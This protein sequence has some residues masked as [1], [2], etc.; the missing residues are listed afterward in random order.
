M[1]GSI[2]YLMKDKENC[3]E[4]YPKNPKSIADSI[5]FILTN[6][7]VIVPPV[8]KSASKTIVNYLSEKNKSHS[9]LLIEKLQKL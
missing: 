3:F 7:E 5:K 4:I 1:V 6:Y 8:T 9:K 2:P